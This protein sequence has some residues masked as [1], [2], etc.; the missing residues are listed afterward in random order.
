MMLEVATAAQLRQALD[1]WRSRGERIALVP[2]MGNLHE[3][4]LQLVDCARER[5][6]RVVV[7]LFVNPTQFGPGEDL[8]N[9]PRTL[10]DDR[11]ALAA[12]GA[13]LLFVPDEAVIYPHGREACVVSVPD[14]SDMLC[15]A[16]RPGH[17]DG[18]ATVVSKLLNLVAPDVAVF[19]EKDF[20]QLMIIRRMVADLFMPV[21]IEGVPTCREVDGLAMSS[22]NRYLSEDERR[23]A[24]ALYQ[25][26]QRVA[27]AL[28]KGRTDY[29]ALV[30][31]ARKFLSEKGFEPDYVEIRRSDDL[32]MPTPSDQALVVLAAARLGK[33]RLIDNLR[34]SLETA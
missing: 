11:A 3:G 21:T 29:D 18:V 24:P 31:S 32:A 34:V 33:A 26:L 1:E 17:F 19:G 12:R 14:L 27:G 6:D 20:Q 2:T 16:A 13:D 7:S 8:D 23:R 4:H 9:Y 15:G 10:D 22:R 30:E 25:A 28:E 5:A